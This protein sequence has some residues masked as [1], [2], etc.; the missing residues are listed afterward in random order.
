MASLSEKKKQASP[1]K[2]A[3]PKAK[4]ATTTSKRATSSTTKKKTAPKSG[5]SNT[6]KKP[7]PKKAPAKKTATKK[8]APAKKAPAKK[9]AAKKTPAKKTP[10]KGKK[11][12][13]AGQ[14]TI[15]GSVFRGVGRP[16]INDPNDV[17]AVVDRIVEYFQELAATGMK[18]TFCGLALALGYSSRT[19][20]WENANA[21]SPISEPIKI[22][23]LTIEAFY[24]GR[25][26]SAA[27][28]GAIF[29]LKN[30]GW[31]DTRKV[32]TEK[33]EAVHVYLPENNRG[34]S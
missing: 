3:A 17:D 18:M 4:K 24:E 20:L 8:A 6:A 29:A 7:S 27:C 16:P 21:G 25:L 32:E 34:R 14:K 5:A 31:E 12:R 19:S 10:A 30:R 28:T 13:G 33:P 2:T 1:Q 11:T 9:T 22:A 26:T 23:M 15:D